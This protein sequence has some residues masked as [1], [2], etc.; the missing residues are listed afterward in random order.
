MADHGI[1]SS[2]EDPNKYNFRFAGR[3]ARELAL[4]EFF[5][6]DRTDAFILKK[7]T[8][9]LFEDSLL[10]FYT[11]QYVRALGGFSNVLKIF[12]GDDLARYFSAL[13]EN[14]LAETD[15]SDI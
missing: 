7:E 6:S 14:L 12:P 9:A 1:F 11:G 10:L 5:D 4:F 13:S 15:R 8:R 2:L 3:Y